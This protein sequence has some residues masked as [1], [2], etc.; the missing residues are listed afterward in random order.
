M[1]KLQILSPD[2]EIRLERELSESAGPLLIIAQDETIRLESSSKANDNVIGALVRDEDGWRLVSSAPESRVVCGPKSAVEMP[3]VSGVALSLGGL[4]FK[5]ETSTAHS[6]S[7][8]V[9]RVG[10]SPIAVDTVLA[11][12]NL[13]ARDSLAKTIS[14]NPAMPSET[15]FEFYPGNDGIEVV[16]HQGERMTVQNGSAFGCGDFRGIVLPAEIARKAIKTHNPF[17]YASR[18]LRR[19]LAI[20]IMLVVG[21]AAIAAGINR[22]ASHWEIAAAADARNAQRIASAPGQSNTGGDEGAYLFTLAF[23]RDLPLILRPQVST[24]AADM[25]VRAHAFTNLAPVVKMEKFLVQVTGIQKA[26]AANRWEIIDSQLKQLDRNEFAGYG[27]EA[28]YDD[29]AEIMDFIGSTIPEVA[30]QASAPGGGGMENISRQIDEM[31][32]GLSDNRFAQLEATKALIADI[33]ARMDALEKYVKSRERLLTAIDDGTV[34]QSLISELAQS[35]GTIDIMFGEGDLAPIIVRERGILGSKLP[36]LCDHEEL[37]AELADLGEMAGLDEVTLKLW[38]DKAKTRTRELDR[39]ARRLYGD[40]RLNA[41]NDP[42]K[43]KAILEKLLRTAPPDSSFG[44]WASK[45]LERIS[46]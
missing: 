12:R 13:V 26:V 15:I 24:I 38:R 46:K 20:A 6:G 21:I 23:F 44:I 34:T 22:R 25:I 8:L 39:Q 2:G 36:M 1:E 45:E 9:W 10:S 32:E 4:I 37:L 11:G 31:I 28:F 7:V 16:S 29:L 27:A 14:V 5:L 19:R 3:L 33:D 43:A 40:Y 18:P 42:E 41:R 35:F 30:L 17:A